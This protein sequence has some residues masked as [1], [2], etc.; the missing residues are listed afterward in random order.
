MDEKL[1]PPSQQEQ[2]ERLHEERVSRRTF[3][4]NVGIAL[5]AIVGIAIA[6][7]VVVYLFGPVMRLSLIHI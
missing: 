1:P 4:M 6:T 5:N 2:Q 3:M 7:P